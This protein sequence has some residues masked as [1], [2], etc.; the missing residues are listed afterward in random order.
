MKSRY[1]KL[2]ALGFLMGAGILMFSAF[3]GARVRGVTP[4]T[5]DVKI[6]T[7]SNTVIIT[8]ISEKIFKI[9]SLPIGSEENIPES[10]SAILKPNA[11]FQVSSSAKD[12]RISTDATELTVDRKTGLIKFLNAD[13][14]LLLEEG[15]TP[16]NN[17][18]KRRIVFTGGE[19]ENFY[20]AGERGHS[21]KLNGDTLVMY[22]R[23]NYGYGAGD[24]R[25]SQMNI[26]VPYFVSDL[27]YGVL[28]DDFSESKLILGDSI[29][30]IS[31]SPSPVSYY[32][33]N[34]EGTLAGTTEGYTSLTGRQPLAPFWS[35]GYITSKYGYHTQ[36]ETLGVID[37][38]KNGGY[39]V[40]GIVLD[41]YWYGQETDMGRL[42]WNKEQWPDHKE[43]LRQLKDKGVNLVAISQ[44]YINKIGAIDNY[45]MLSEA[46]LLVKDENGKTHDV[47]TWVGDAGMFD[48]SNPQTREWLWT[49]YKDLTD[50]G[51]AGW[52][53]DLGEPEVHPRT[54]VHYNGLT[55]PQ[56]HN[57][58]GNDW[59]EIIFDGFKKE[60]P[61]RRL[62][63]LM[64]GGTAG[65]QRYSVFPWSTDVSRSWEGFMP[66]VNIMLNSSLSGLGYMSSDI[67]GFAVDP[68]NPTN[69]ELYVRWLQM[70]AFTPTFRT[71][72]QNKPEPYNYPQ[73][74]NISRKFIKMRYEWLPY[75][76]TLAFE[77]AKDG[78]PLVR[79]LNYR[80][81]NPDD[82]YSNIQD[83]YLWGDNVLV[84]PVMKAGARSRQ[85]IFPTG[86]WINW[87]NTALSY[88][89]GTTAT[90]KAPLEEM[91]LFVKA[92][93][94][95]PQY[96]QPIENVTQY[97]PRFLTIKYFPSEE[98]SEY[99]LYEDNRISP[100]SIEDNEYQAIT[101]YGKTA[102]GNTDITLSSKG[103]YQDMPD[104]RMLTF[105]IVN[106]NKMPANVSV[107][108]Y[109]NMER[110]DSLKSIRQYGWYY[111]AKAK[112]LYVVFPW[113]N[114]TVTINVK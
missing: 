78:A 10:R 114:D 15:S 30:Y 2:P 72:A 52:W 92:G 69:P 14:E 4:T 47:T 107:S 100:T 33:I 46:G 58:Y 36:D 80:G 102:N 108:T 56:Y 82:K 12:V 88:N 73:Y 40:D 21:L 37:T 7:D 76:Y 90:V 75:N 27:G 17:P 103:R 42:E 25:I 61:D 1:I 96:T 66:Q 95:I 109:P 23:Q 94:F 44:P 39:P 93:S 60:Y 6:T 59:S 24:P 97:D 19:D 98:E 11:K 29:Q 85:V 110:F 49:R 64:R 32:F 20:G 87:Y 22:N 3:S 89:G 112:S 111:D 38:L 67:G 77:N 28:F 57:Q 31:E 106:V 79:P 16:I 54:M 5:R 34:G 9:T 53:G 65:L 86:K 105:E 51:I 43:M 74:E 35:L 113:S 45:N 50:D 71:H 68:N 26:T 104:V 101:F 99:T 83:E 70:G 8:P 13:G 91:P 41:L 81:N 84:A 63:L 55:A 18:E 62:M 48:V